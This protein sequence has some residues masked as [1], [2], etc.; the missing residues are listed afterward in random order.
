MTQKYF[1]ED[2]LRRDL[3]VHLLQEADKLAISLKKKKI[4]SLSLDHA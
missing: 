3:K 1:T 4:A 2:E